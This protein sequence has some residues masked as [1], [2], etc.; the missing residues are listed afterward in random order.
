MLM[1][2]CLPCQRLEKTNERP[3]WNCSCKCPAAEMET[4]IFVTSSRQNGVH[5]RFNTCCS[6]PPCTQVLGVGL[7]SAAAG[8]RVIGRLPAPGDA[9]WKCTTCPVQAS[10]WP[11]WRK[12]ADKGA[13]LWCVAGRGAQ[14]GEG[15]GLAR[16]REGEHARE[17]AQ[18]R[19][20]RLRRAPVLR[21]TPHFQTT[22]VQGS[23]TP[24][25]HAATPGRLL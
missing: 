15:V 7:A 3:H 13:K 21:R 1:R 4:L 2:V 9:L 8:K 10:R 19:A 17:E 16:G 12:A 5:P 6:A 14:V 22:G 11:L 23:T 20:V 24:I 18:A 25:S